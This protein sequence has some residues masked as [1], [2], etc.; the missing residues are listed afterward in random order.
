[1]SKTEVRGTKTERVAQLRALDLFAPLDEA[2]PERLA[3]AL[4][5]R[6]YAPGTAILREGDEAE[7]FYV[8]VAGEVDIFRGARLIVVRG[9]G[10]Y[11]GEVALMYR[12]PRTASAFARSELSLYALDGPAF[13][14][15]VNSDPRSR[16]IAAAVA[17]ERIGP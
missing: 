16:D 15:A 1:V 17:A 3:G 9:P 6:Q 10:E 12:I 7:Y 2:W 4:V 14:A 8:I 5:D 11:F 13:L